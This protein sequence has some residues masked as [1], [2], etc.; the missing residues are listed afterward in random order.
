MD[1]QSLTQPD[2]RKFISDNEEQDVAGLALKKP[3]A[4]DWNYALILDQIKSRQKAR[5]KVPAWFAAAPSALIFPPAAVVEQASSETT[6]LYKAA[7]VKGERFVD[8]S[9]GMGVDC[10]AFARNFQRGDCVERDGIAAALLK[11]NFAAL[12]L[13]HVKTHTQNAEDFIKSMPTVNFIYLDPQR[14]DGSK[15]GKFLLQDT[16]P[17]IFALL[18]ALKKQTR[19]LMI[20][21]S[22][23]LDIHESL[24]KL[25]YVREVHVLEYN[26]DC[27]EVLYLLDMNTNPLPLNDIPITGINLD[28]AGQP[29]SALTF[30]P[31]EESA[32]NARLS[33]PLAYLFEPSPA[34]QK[35]GCFN[36]LALRYDVAK[37]H[38]HTH[39]Y[40]AETP[41]PNFPGRSFKIHGL[42]PAQSGKIPLDKANLTLRNFPGETAT[43]RK[44]LKL[45]DGGED[46]LFACTLHNNMKTLIHGRKA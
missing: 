46:Y 24:I 36:T 18:P 45:K 4:P 27:K 22:P 2:I 12:N 21:T 40:T 7:L 20:K 30:T 23:M 43:L 41:R 37:L 6:A 31:G 25:Q 3:P 26:G 14:R 33:A 1:W 29:L 13:D 9:G 16:S 15:K 11:Y 28:A 17:D 42:Y 39:L 35:S 44:K 19:Q 5:K 34:F 32:S 10:A 38:P 8:L